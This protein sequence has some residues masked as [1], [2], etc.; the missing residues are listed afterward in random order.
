VG[1]DLASPML[2]KEESPYKPDTLKTRSNKAFALAFALKQKQTESSF[3]L[4]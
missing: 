4:L 3:T 1:G 2:F